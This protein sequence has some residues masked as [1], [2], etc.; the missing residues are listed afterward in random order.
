MLACLFH[1]VGPP[2][3]LGLD[4]QVG[5]ILG[6]VQASA[7]TEISS[8]C[9]AASLP[10]AQLISESIR[11][12]D[13]CWAT[14]M[15]ITIKAIVRSD[16]AE[17]TKTFTK[18]LEFYETSLPE[19]QHEATFARLVDPQ[20]DLHGF[21]LRDADNNVKGL[22]HYL[23]HSNPWTEKPHCYLSDLYVDTTLRGKGHGRGLLLKVQDIAK[24]RGCARL[25]V[26]PSE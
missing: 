20:G 6:K 16:F 3:Y 24:D 26:S 7:Y 18:Y 4:R 11:A 19:S 22:A 14:A 17:W 1:H 8:R 5:Y 15:S 2:R 13:P 23:F 9:P 25:Y 12:P 10:F 21:I